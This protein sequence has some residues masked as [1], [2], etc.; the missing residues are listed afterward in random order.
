MARKVKQREKAPPDW[1]NTLLLWIGIATTTL[2]A[3]AALLVA[4]GK[5]GEAVYI[6]CNMVPS[7]PWCAY[8]Q[9]PKLQSYTSSRVDG[10]HNQ[11]E[12]CE[13]VAKA[14]RSQYP[15]FDIAWIGSETNQ[16]DTFRHTTYVYHCEFTAK[17]KARTF[18]TYVI[19]GILAIGILALLGAGTWKARRIGKAD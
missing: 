1:V 9:P 4:I 17:P 12:Y 18:V 16:T 7:L 10:G 5:V 11:G 3:V 14:Y 8:Q 2:G 15:A 19:Y 13:P 6:P